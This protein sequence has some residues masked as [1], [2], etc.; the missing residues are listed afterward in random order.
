MAKD[1]NYTKFTVE[2]EEVVDADGNTVELSIDYTAP[3]VAIVDA[4]KDTQLDLTKPEFKKL[5]K[6]TRVPKQ[7]VKTK[8]VKQLRNKKGQFLSFADS[9]IVR[10]IAKDN[11]ISIAKA[12]DVFAT[13]KF[14]S[15]RSLDIQ[16]HSILDAVKRGLDF[17][18]NK[19]GNPNAIIR[20]KDSSGRKY[21][22]TGKNAYKEA[23]KLINQENSKLYSISYLDGR[24]K[25]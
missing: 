15:K 16:Q 2:A 13:K 7:K 4:Q 24:K 5:R 22:F 17:K 23:V 20:V 8:K 1:K 14:S 18:D 11:K 6:Q 3:D 19:V 12:K 25:L 21:T 10:K 9:Q